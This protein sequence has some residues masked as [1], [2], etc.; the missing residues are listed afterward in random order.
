M[1]TEVF[2]IWENA[3]SKSI[4]QHSKIAIPIVMVFCAICMWAF[5][6]VCTISQLI[7][8]AAKWIQQK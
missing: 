1:I 6:N 5:Y 8:E 4:E 3:V 7:W 2:F